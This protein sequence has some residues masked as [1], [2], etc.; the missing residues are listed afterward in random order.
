ME[1]KAESIIGSLYDGTLNSLYF[2]LE[3]KENSL[4]P[5]FTVSQP[6]LN[7]ENLDIE[8]F[9]SDLGQV[10][11]VQCPITLVPSHYTITLI[12]EPI[13]CAYVEKSSENS[14][15]QQLISLISA[16]DNEDAYLKEL[17]G[18]K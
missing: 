14:A 1:Y 15:I 5:P 9:E 6:K 4:T 11:I 17:L 12:D 13:K 8:Y 16:M 3:K 10:M 2:L 7:M 18:D